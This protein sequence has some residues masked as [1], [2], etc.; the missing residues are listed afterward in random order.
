MFKT[1]PASDS[2]DMDSSSSGPSYSR[3]A[4]MPATVPQS[5][6]DLNLIT[7]SEYFLHLRVQ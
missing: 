5:A 4:D 6:V 7:T 2:A 1:I 3:L